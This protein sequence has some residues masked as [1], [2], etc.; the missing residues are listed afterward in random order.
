M[1]R[2]PFACIL[3]AA[4]AAL[5]VGCS[6]GGEVGVPERPS[7]TAP[8]RTVIAPSGRLSYWPEATTHLRVSLDGDAPRVELDAGPTRGFTAFWS[9]A[10]TRDGGSGFFYSDAV[11]GGSETVVSVAKDVRDVA[12]IHDATVFPT[13]RAPVGPVMPGQ[14]VL[15]HHLPT[16]RYLALVLEKVTPLDPHEAGAGPYAYAEVTWYLGEPGAVDFG[17][18]SLTE[19]R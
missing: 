15:V 14:I 12:A 2:G 3:V 10:S 18:S 13:T 19:P 7:T 9:V 11:G 16:D 5:V 1:E 6:G 8:A 17:A 4:A